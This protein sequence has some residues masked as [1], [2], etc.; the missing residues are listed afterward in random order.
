MKKFLFSLFN[1]FGLL[2]NNNQSSNTNDSVKEIVNEEA[3]LFSEETRNNRLDAIHTKMSQGRFVE[4]KILIEEYQKDF[5][6]LYGNEKFTYQDN[7]FDGGIF[8]ENTSSLGLLSLL[9]PMTE[10]FFRKCVDGSMTEEEAFELERK[11]RLQKDLLDAYERQDI[12]DFHNLVKKG[13]DVSYVYHG[14]RYEG[15]FT[16]WQRVKERRGSDFYKYFVKHYGHLSEVSRALY[17]EQQ[18]RE[19]V[20]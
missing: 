11:K 9:D 14:A 16:I 12:W 4:A 13:A 5:G 10:D 2:G 19:L 7:F 18:I 20:C 1:L 6:R 8:C 15:L 3:F 17:R